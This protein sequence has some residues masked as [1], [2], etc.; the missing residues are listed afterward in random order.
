[1]LPSPESSPVDAA[2]QPPA[3]LVERAERAAGASRGARA[4]AGAPGVGPSRP[5][6]ERGV[7]VAGGGAE[8]GAGTGGGDSGSCGAT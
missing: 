1:M 2:G 4:A 6:E 3:R 7:W 5:G 8:G